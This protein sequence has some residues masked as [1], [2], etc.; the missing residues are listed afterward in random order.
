MVAANEFERHLAY[1]DGV[2]EDPPPPLVLGSATGETDVQK[3]VLGDRDLHA[4]VGRQLV[5]VAADLRITPYM[6]GLVLWAA[7]VCEEAD[8]DDVLLTSVMAD[9]S[10]APTAGLIGYFINTVPLR[11]RVSPGESLETLAPRARAA[12]LEAFQYGD[13]PLDLILDR[14]RASGFREQLVGG[15]DID[16][17]ERDELA[18]HLGNGVVGARIA[19]TDSS[20]KF[21]LALSVVCSGDVPGVRLKGRAALFTPDD[22]DD[23][24]DKF[25]ETLH[26]ALR[27]PSTPLR[28]LEAAPDAVDATTGLVPVR[29]AALA[30]AAPERSAIEVDG[31][32]LTRGE[33]QSLSA[34]LASELAQNGVRAGDRVVL[35]AKRSPVAIAAMFACWRVGAA[36]VPVDVEQPSARLAAI[37][38]DAEPRIILTD[39]AGLE[40]TPVPVVQLRDHRSYSSGA[41]PTDALPLNDEYDPEQAAYIIYTSGST[42]RPKGVEV[43]HRAVAAYIDGIAEPYGLSESDRVLQFHSLAFDASVEEIFGALSNG[44]A[45]VLRPDDLLG[46]ARRLTEFVDEQ[47]LTVLALPTAFWHEFTKQMSDSNLELPSSLRAVVFGGEAARRDVVDTWHQ[48]VEGVELLN[49]YGPTEMTVAVFA[50]VMRPGQAGEHVSIGTALGTVDALIVGEDGLPVAHGEW[51]ELLLSGPQMAHGYYG[52]PD[53]TEAVFVD[54]R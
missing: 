1:W 45:L 35:A 5:E 37:V 38:E 9:R 43:P 4:D 11:L 18:L 6:L 17:R 24:L 14:A 54:S 41:A 3:P 12:V 36:Y 31:L 42:G 34:V 52:R 40:L 7:I 10:W 47:A 13:V 29:V 49:S 2:L 50:G 30:A 51:G 39:D 32:T 33:L 53:L 16:V 44:S 25:I 23:L 8:Q 19:L 21:D 15:T 26:K 27:D 20:M 48:C 46:S 28:E 22:I